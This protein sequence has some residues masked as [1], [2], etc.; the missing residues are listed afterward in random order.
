[1]KMNIFIAKWR[2]SINAINLFFRAIAFN[3]HKTIIVII[4]KAR[5][6]EPTPAEGGAVA[7]LLP[8]RVDGVVV[9]R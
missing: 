9:G 3:A 2:C 5:D 4:V 8:R 6:G 7:I 1:M